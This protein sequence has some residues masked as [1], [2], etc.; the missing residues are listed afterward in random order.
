M[1]YKICQVIFLTQQWLALSCS[2]CKALHRYVAHAV[3]CMVVLRLGLSS[4]MAEQ[5]ESVVTPYCIYTFSLSAHMKSNL[6]FQLFRALVSP[7]VG[8]SHN[9][10]C[11]KSIISFSIFPHCEIVFNLNTHCSCFPSSVL[12]YL[13]IYSVLLH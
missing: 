3:C 4:C 13:F 7:T 2:P 1:R 5:C 8:F 9:N 12:F 11:F 6:L 10:L